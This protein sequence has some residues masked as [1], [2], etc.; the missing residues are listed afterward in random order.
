MSNSDINEITKNQI[1][2][3]ATDELI[4]EKNRQD[5]AIK[6]ASNYLYNQNMDQIAQIIESQNT[7]TEEEQQ[8]MNSTYYKNYQNVINNLDNLIMQPIYDLNY[9][10][11]YSHMNLDS[12]NTKE[13]ESCMFINNIG[14]PIPNLFVDRLKDA[15]HIKLDELD[16]I[17][18]TYHEVDVI[19]TEYLGGIENNKLIKK[20]DTYQVILKLKKEKSKTKVK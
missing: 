7:Y 15:I 3:N 10:Y 20:V 11:V 9:K 4:E 6:E 14:F 5:E 16:R 13:V 17:D 1:F 8:Y 12:S 18:N 19:E 2:Q